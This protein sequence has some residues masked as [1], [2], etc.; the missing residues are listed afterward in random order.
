MPKTFYVW[1]YVLKSETLHQIVFELDLISIWAAAL[2]GLFTFATRVIFSE[3][4]EASKKFA[5]DSYG[6]DY[7]VSF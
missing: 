7:V 6:L 2:G 4:V 1:L 5:N 3:Y